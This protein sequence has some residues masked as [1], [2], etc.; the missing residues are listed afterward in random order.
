MET[1]GQSEKRPEGGTSE[2]EGQQRKGEGKGAT[3]G[4][5]AGERGKTEKN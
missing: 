2:G 1:W 3:G 5:G 4:G